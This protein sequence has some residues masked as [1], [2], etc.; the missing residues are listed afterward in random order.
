M[1][2]LVLFLMVATIAGAVDI[3]FNKPVQNDLFSTW[4][5]QVRTN[6]V[7]SLKMDTSITASNKPTGTM[8][9]DKTNYYLTQWNGSSFADFNLKFKNGVVINESGADSDTRIEG[10]TLQNLFCIDASADKIGINTATPGSVLDI[11][12]TTT[13][14]NGAVVFNEGSGDYDFR[15][16]GN[17]D[18]NLF[19][20]D[21]GNDR[22]GIGTATP[23]YKLSINAGTATYAAQIES[24]SQT[25][26]IILKDSVQY[27]TLANIAGEFQVQTNN[28]AET[29]LAT[30]NGKVGIGTTSPDEE[31][32][33]AGDI[34][35]TGDLFTVD[36][37]DY[38]GSSTV[39][40]WSSY[41]SKIIYYKKIG[42]RVFVD[43]LISGTSNSTAVTFTLPYTA[44]NNTIGF[45]CAMQYTRDN[46]TYKTTPGAAQL[47]AN[48]ATVY[49]H[50]DMG[51][52]NVWTASNAKTCAGQFWFEAQ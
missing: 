47:A 50:P 42:S 5:E 21:A 15:I 1:R 37:T 10:D 36:W 7:Y 38:G 45:G 44:V 11:F 51:Y 12:G 24:T 29:V 18:A 41:S 22:I 16:E 48:S 3:D 27:C 2:Y 26:E 49:C 31:L 4:Y 46:G 20:V 35:V 6:E 40:G 32:H 34:K 33:V 23:S 17:G 14:Q 39:V 9:F 13:Q 30:L 19:Y 25:C 43:F 8:A 52:T 28:E